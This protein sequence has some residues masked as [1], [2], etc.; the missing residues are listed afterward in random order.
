[1]QVKTWPFNR[2]VEKLVVDSYLFSMYEGYS[3]LPI[4]FKVYIFDS[5]FFNIYFFVYIFFICG[6][7]WIEKR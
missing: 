1:V 3:I 2:K 5:Y 7:E 4:F 6:E